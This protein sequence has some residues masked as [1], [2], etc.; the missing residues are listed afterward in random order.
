MSDLQYTYAVARIRS[1]EM[2]LFNAQTIEQLLAA[3]SYDECLRLLA[4]K[5]WG[6]MDSH[7]NAESLLAQEREKTWNLMGELVDDLSVFDVFL[8]ANDY[9]NLKAAIKLVCTDTDDSG[10]FISHGTIDSKVI[11]DAVKEHNFSLLPEAMQAP[12]EE[13]Y[14]ALLQTHDGQ[15]CDII[16]DKAALEAIY[17]A[18]KASKNELI[19]KYAEL[20]VV[21]ANMKIAVRCN[22]T[23]KSVD[24]IKRALATCDTLDIPKLAHTAAESA[25]AICDYLASTDYAAAVTALQ[26]S[27]SAFERWCD[28]VIIEYIRP[29]Q[30]QAF[31]IGPLAA[32]ILGRENEIKSVRIILSGKLNE[33]PEASIRERV[34]EMYV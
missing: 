12:A 27:P 32:Y 33:L 26:Q 21:A 3:K 24:F 14:S 7:P 8:Y 25:E 15:L 5:G 31:G 28:N 22:R 23:G 2:A 10:L 4:D 13:A 16:I 20:T 19:E 30:F 6:G 34:R 18:G 1:K 11:L 29:Q 9:H 17:A